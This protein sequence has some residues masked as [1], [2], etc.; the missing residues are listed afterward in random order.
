MQCSPLQPTQ[1]LCLQRMQQCRSEHSQH[2]YT[3]ARTHTHTHMH[4]RARTHTHTH[5]HAH[6]PF[7]LMTCLTAA[8]SCSSREGSKS[9][10]GWLFTTPLTALQFARTSGPNL[11]I[12]QDG[13]GSY[14]R[15]QAMQKKKKV[16]CFSP[17]VLLIHLIGLV[18]SGR[19]DLC[20]WAG[21]VSKGR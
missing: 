13:A 12:R 4:A 14:K 5:T 20:Q 10:Y 3:R 17:T 11:S 8:V 19:R 2:T 21:G 6:T 18:E 16:V 7:P 1:I 9:C 15:C